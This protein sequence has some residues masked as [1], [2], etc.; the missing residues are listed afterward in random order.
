MIVLTLTWVVLF[1]MPLMFINFG[2]PFTFKRFLNHLHIPLSLFI[3]YFV[4][5]YWLAPC[6]L[7]KGHR[8]HYLIVNLLLVTFLATGMH[9]WFVFS[10]HTWYKEV[11]EQDRISLISVGLHDS[12]WK[13][14]YFG[15]D[16]FNMMVAGTVATTIRL[17]RSWALMRHQQVVF[18]LE[19]AEIE[20]QLLKYQVYPHFLLNTLNNIYA[21]V[22]IDKS[23]AL[24]AINQLGAL[25]RHVLYDNKESTIFLKDEVAF[26]D[27][28]IELMMLRVPRNVEIRK[29]INID[30]APQARIT[31]FIFISLIEN[32]FKHGISTSTPCFISITIDAD[33]DH[34][35]CDISNSNHPKQAADDSGSGIG[36]QQV[37]RRLDLYYSNQYEWTYGLEDNDCI[38]HSKITLYDTKLHHH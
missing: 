22:T 16:V 34:I 36:L 37:R 23:K 27:A 6:Y 17:S 20:N 11:F 7:M 9:Q 14:F 32:A 24:A 19:R 12:K 26:I 28:Y 18:E 2:Q 30:K 4:N 38:Y 35:T 29:N 10:S 31:P 15:R 1:L 5:Y 13:L 3:A 8:W 21:L 25:L 33:G